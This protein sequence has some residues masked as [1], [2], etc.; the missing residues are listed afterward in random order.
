MNA[1]TAL[2]TA[3]AHAKSYTIY[4]GD[5]PFFVSR[6]RRW[7]MFRPFPAH[8]YHIVWAQLE[9][10]VVVNN[11]N[12]GFACILLFCVSRFCVY[13]PDPLTGH[14][15]GI[16]PKAQQRPVSQQHCILVYWPLSS[17]AQRP[18]ARAEKQVPT[19]WS[20]EGG[21]TLTELD[22]WAGSNICLRS[23]SHHNLSQIK[24][25]HGWCMFYVSSVFVW[26]LCSLQRQRS[27]SWS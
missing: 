17:A 27:E 15:S 8:I 1:V 23:R 21:D 12:V 3:C 25:T 16:C 9:W 11:W 7:W 10:C 13:S 22:D 24:G 5:C 18:L 2:F 19:R 4:C 20:E 6:G 14:I 26:V